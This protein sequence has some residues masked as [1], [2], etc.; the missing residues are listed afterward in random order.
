MKRRDL[1]ICFFCWG[2]K[3]GARP[4][5]QAV[6][7]TSP[8][9][10]R[11]ISGVNRCSTIR[12]GPAGG[13]SARSTARSTRRRSASISRSRCRRPKATSGSSTSG[14]R[15]RGV[16]L[17]LMPDASTAGPGGWGSA[18]RPGSAR[19]CKAMAREPPLR[20]VE[21]RAHCRGASG[22]PPTPGL[23][24]PTARSRRSA[25]PGGLGRRGRV[26]TAWRRRRP[27]RN[28]CPRPVA[29]RSA[30]NGRSTL[31]SRR[32]P[33]GLRRRTAQRCRVP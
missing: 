3:T 20:P 10:T 29:R 1:E 24:R 21:A 4:Y 8:G 6:P 5:L 16:P 27:R 7:A 14:S 2:W 15:S 28:P 18:R 26:V 12:R 9:P 32:V 30:W 22:P 31:R 17:A 33:S 19:S 25:K 23:G 13:C 11:T